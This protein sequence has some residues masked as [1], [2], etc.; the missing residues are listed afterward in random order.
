M[1]QASEFWEKKAPEPPPRTHLH[2]IESPI[3][4]KLT[5]RQQMETKW[6]PA[7]SEVVD[8]FEKTLERS[9]KVKENVNKREKVERMKDGS[10]S[11]S[12]SK[13]NLLNG[14]FVDVFSKTKGMSGVYEIIEL[15]YLVTDANLFKKRL[16]LGNDIRL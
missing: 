10:R 5:T 4:P 9:K 16:S 3:V 11:R 13:E 1:N 2:S 6:D 15:F 12:R 14:E 8:D 7:L